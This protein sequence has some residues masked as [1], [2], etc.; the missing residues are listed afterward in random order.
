MSDEK[1]F[2]AKDAAA[3]EQQA[4]MPG[5]SSGFTSG[6]NSMERDNETMTEKDWNKTQ[7]QSNVFPWTS[8]GLKEYVM[9][10]VDPAQ[11]SGPL[12]AY[13]FMTGFM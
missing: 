3:V 13:C 1:N 7:Y 8:V 5:P 6:A 10:D 11:S 4:V 9:M 2:H 12:S